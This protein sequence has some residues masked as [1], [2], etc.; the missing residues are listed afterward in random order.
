MDDQADNISHGLT[1]LSP[2]FQDAAAAFLG[3]TQAKQ[4]LDAREQA[5]ILIALNVA[6]THLNVPALRGH[7]GA[8]LDAGATGPEIAEVF[9]LVSVLGIHAVSL[10]LPAL[11]DTLDDAGL[12]D[13]STDLSAEKENLKQ[14]FM[15]ARGYWN[16]FWEKVLHFDPDLLAAYARFSSVP[17]EEGVLPGRLRELIYVAIDASTTHMFD[18]GT[19]Q[20]M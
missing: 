8:A 4:L 1:T 10:G 14:G 11:L 3:V 7:I 15:A 20:H 19:R 13:H 5:L 12:A 16:P 2:T 18:E 9:Q 6:V 17:W